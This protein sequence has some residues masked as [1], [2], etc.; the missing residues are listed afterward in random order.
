M[1][2]GGASASDSNT[3][4]S[5]ND[6]TYGTHS[7][8]LGDDWIAAFKAAQGNLNAG[9]YTADQQ[10]AIDLGLGALGRSD[11]AV[12]DANNSF[13]AIRDQYG[14]R[15]QQLYDISTQGPHLLGAAPTS[16]AGQAT[17]TTSD[18]AGDITAQSGASQMGQYFDPFIG[19]VVANSVND[20]D[21][22]VDRTLNNMRASRDA[23]GA[24][25][26]RAAIG[27]AS[28][29]GDA[30]RGL[31]TLV[32]GLYSNAFNTAAGYGQQDANRILSADQSNQATRQQNNQFN[33]GLLT[34]TSKFN[35]GQTTQNNQFNAGLLNDRDIANQNSQNQNDQTRL[36]A[37]EDMQQNLRDQTNLTDTQLNDIFKGTQIDT[38]A[39]QALFQAGQISQDQLNQI[40][41]LAQAG[42]GYSYTQN[43]NGSSNSNTVSV[44]ANAHFGV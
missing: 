3:S 18:Y 19:D 16:V 14:Q 15:G 36:H 24:F 35:A 39:A 34:D 23:S 22:N 2:G 41:Q 4:K 12:A 38:E 7:P 17:G 28:Y 5:S 32:S 43:S 33:A 11:S 10:K 31:G 1:A 29:L 9:G 37:I 20:Y 40:L 26:D 21:T 25:G 8:I 6:N 42:N 44:S 13:D 27:D 30:T